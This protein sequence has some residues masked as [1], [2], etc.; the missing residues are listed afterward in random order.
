VAAQVGDLVT[1]GVVCRCGHTLPEIYAERCPLYEQYADIVVPLD[2]CD[3]PEAVE[4]ILQA[5]DAA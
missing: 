1:R 3:V 4:K 2:G 5:I